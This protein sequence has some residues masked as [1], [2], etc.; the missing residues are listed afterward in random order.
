MKSDRRDQC[1]PLLL[2]PRGD[3]VQRAGAEIPAAQH[4]EHHEHK[5]QDCEPQFHH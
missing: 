5:A 2:V 4:R 1:P 3:E